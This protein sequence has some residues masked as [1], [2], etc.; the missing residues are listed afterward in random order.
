MT[1][2]SKCSVQCLYTVCT[3]LT[4]E[5][6][7]AETGNTNIG[8]YAE[9]PYTMYTTDSKWSEH[10]PGTSISLEAWTQIPLIHGISPLLPPL[11]YPPLHSNGEWFRG[12][13]PLT[14]LK[15]YNAV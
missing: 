3:R 11:P 5:F 4:C 9:T 1:T 10:F 12:I 6:A 7:C 8:L 14:F 15:S 13:T 2:E